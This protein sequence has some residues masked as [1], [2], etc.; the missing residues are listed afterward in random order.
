M[1]CRCWPKDICDN[2]QS[3]NSNSTEQMCARCMPV[4]ILHTLF[5][6][7][8]IF[9]STLNWLLHL[10]AA[11]TLAFRFLMGERA[12]TRSLLCHGCWY[13]FVRWYFYFSFVFPSFS[14][15]IWIQ[16]CDRFYV[17]PRECLRVHRLLRLYFNTKTKKKRHRIHRELLATTTRK[18]VTKTKCINKK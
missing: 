8:D 10:S 15:C 11:V 18:K 6:F 4:S 13:C 16:F 2:F 12:H 14:A 17:R 5:E 1:C 7:V 9:R 3:N